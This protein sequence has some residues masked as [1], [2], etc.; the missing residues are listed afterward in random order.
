MIRAM[1]ALIIGI[2][3]SLLACG[4]SKEPA[5]YALA[6][7][8]AAA[9]T[10]APPLVELRRPGI[11]GYLDRADIVKGV[12]G[13]RLRVDG[14]ERWAEP[15]GDMV[16]RVVADDLSTRLQGTQ[17]FLESGAISAVPSVILAIDIL[18]L[19][20]TDDG[21]LTLVAEVAAEV[22]SDPKN[23]RVQRLTF[24]TKP[25]STDT[26]GMVAAVSDLLGKLA[27]GIADLLV[28]H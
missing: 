12:A 5:Y 23:A 6:P 21:A 16:G 4:G 7:R 27:D 19:D 18:K 2:A 13:Y 17:V 25:A 20:A 22:P 8:P 9:R 10:G 11:A 28:A 15:L 14:D 24:S 1:K 26:A 3:T